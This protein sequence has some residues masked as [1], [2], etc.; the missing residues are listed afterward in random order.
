MD[1]LQALIITPHDHYQYVTIFTNMF[2]IVWKVSLFGVIELELF[3][4]YIFKQ[5]AVI[6]IICQLKGLVI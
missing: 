2:S 1:S 3:T 6:L 5:T 4:V